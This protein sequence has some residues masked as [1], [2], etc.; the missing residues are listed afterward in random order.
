LSLAGLV[1][2]S[3]TQIVIDMAAMTVVQTVSA[4]ATNAIGKLTSGDFFALDPKDSD[5][6]TPTWCKLLYTATG[7]VSAVACVYRKAYF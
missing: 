5:T 4:V 2:A 1:T 6:V 3:A 7:T